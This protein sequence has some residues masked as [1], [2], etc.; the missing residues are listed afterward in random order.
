[1]FL[2]FERI[3]LRFAKH[4]QEELSFFSLKT[5]GTSAL[6]FLGER[7]R[8]EWGWGDCQKSSSRASTSLQRGSSIIHGPSLQV[9]VL[10]PM[11]GTAGPS[12][13]QHIPHIH[14]HTHAHAH[15]HVCTCG[16]LLVPDFE[17]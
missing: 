9:L 4:C 8:W 14:I 11:P 2:D 3:I 7:W 1:M 15:T 6:H 16:L 13:E 17:L 12:I 5:G 10:C